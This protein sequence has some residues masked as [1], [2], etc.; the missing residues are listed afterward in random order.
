MTD[1]I[2]TKQLTLLETLELIQHTANGGLNGDLD[3]NTAFQQI[4]YIAEKMKP[5]V[6]FYLN[7]SDAFAKAFPDKE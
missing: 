1:K 3:S 4:H 6:S 2:T 5:G 7:M